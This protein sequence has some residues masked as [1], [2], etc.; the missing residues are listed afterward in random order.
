MQILNEIDDTYLLLG[1]LNLLRKYD[2]SDEEWIKYE[3][4][5]MI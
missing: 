1:D 5:A 2:Y 3:Y 4:D